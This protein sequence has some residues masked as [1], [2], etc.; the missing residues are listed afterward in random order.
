MLV[1]ANDPPAEREG[2]TVYEE[3]PRYAAP[4]TQLPIPLGTTKQDNSGLSFFGVSTGPG[5]GSV[6]VVGWR[7][8]DDSVLEAHWAAG[9]GLPELTD[10]WS[11]WESE[12]DRYSLVTGSRLGVCGEYYLGHGFAVAFDL[13]AALRRSGSPLWADARIEWY[14]VEGIQVSLG[15]DLT[16]GRWECGWTITP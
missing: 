9:S 11:L 7:L 6:I 14:P 5:D 2:E 15:W 1:S 10:R 3:A 12:T 13:G 8:R 16:R 4:D